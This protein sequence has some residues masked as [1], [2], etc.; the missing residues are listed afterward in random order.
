[1]SEA[2][3]AANEAGGAAVPVPERVA[4]PVLHQTWAHTAFV[5]WR[6][7]PEA[8]RPLVPHPLQVDVDDGTA[9]VSLVLFRAEQSRLPGLP[10]LPF[11]STFTEVNLRTYVTAPGDR[12]ALWF[13]AL[14]A[15]N[16]LIVLGGRAFAGVPYNPATARTAVDGD[17]V[18]HTSRR[19]RE[20]GVATRVRVRRG[21]P[22]SA[23]ELTPLE[24]SLS[25]RWGAYSVVGGR[26]RYTPVEHELWPLHH[27]EL[28]ALDESL[29]RASRLPAPEGEPIVRYAPAVHATLGLH[30]S[31]RTA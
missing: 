10:P 26:L 30:R 24:H 6:Y 16:P 9:W 11:G 12:P 29:T 31:A 17:T 14:E 7:P 15:P 3:T 23:E 20:R 1:M 21:A 2:E 8:L 27:A 5:H 13:L 22:L 4:C 18:E 28:L 19:V 25:A